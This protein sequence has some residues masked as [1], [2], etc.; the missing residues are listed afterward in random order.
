LWRK[1]GRENRST[2]LSTLWIVIA[3]ADVLQIGVNSHGDVGWKRPGRCRPDHQIPGRAIVPRFRHP[4]NALEIDE[5][6][7]SRFLPVFELSLGE[8]RS[9]GD[10]PV[11]RFELST[12]V[13]AFDQVGQNIEN[14]GLKARIESE[15]WVRPVA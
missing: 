12:N 11:D 6:T 8:R 9:V 2:G 13:T 3:D 1:L 7:R 5:N 4:R 14:A 10:A 15:V